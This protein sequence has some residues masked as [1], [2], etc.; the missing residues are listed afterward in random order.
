MAKSVLDYKYI[1][2]ATGPHLLKAGNYEIFQPKI[3]LKRICQPLCRY[4]FCLP[5]SQAKVKVVS[6]FII[7][8]HK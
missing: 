4:I 1:L 8:S 2:Y 5:P 7:D 3:S 6:F